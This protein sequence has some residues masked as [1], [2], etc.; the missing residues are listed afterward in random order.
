MASPSA[1]IHLA[2]DIR[3]G[4][5]A[6]YETD[7]EEEHI[8]QFANLSGDHNPLHVDAAFAATTNFSARIAHGAYQFGLA[9]AMAG[10]YLP[11]QYSLLTT[12]ECKFLEPLYFPARVR[13]SGRVAAWNAETQSGRLIV[14]VTTLKDDCRVSEFLIR[15]GLSDPRAET[16]S[17]TQSEPVAAQVGGET[18]GKVILVTGASGGIGQYLCDSLKGNFQIISLIRRADGQGTVSEETADSTIVADL[19]IGQWRAELADTLAGRSLYAV[20]HAAWPGMPRGGLIN[21]TED[22]LDRQVR[23]GI[24]TT[25]EL[26]RALTEFAPKSGGRLIAIGSTLGSHHP[27]PAVAAYSLG[28]AALENTIRLV[29]PE[30]AAKKILANVVAPSLLPVGINRQMGQRQQQLEQARIPLARLCS[31]EDLCGTVDFLLSEQ[32]AFMTGQVLKLTGGEI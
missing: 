20:V 31:P 23:F 22:I 26:A 10:M 21:S 6:S 19:E 15:F 9:S 14:T 24:N 32:S 5:E 4:L 28:K 1:R 2:R 27:N 12:V 16:Q 13:V 25:L 18:T 11:G 17:R 29:A 7:V 8:L 3:A 30:L